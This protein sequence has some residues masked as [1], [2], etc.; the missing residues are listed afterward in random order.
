MSVP[1]HCVQDNVYVIESTTDQWGNTCDFV[2]SKVWVM[3]FNNEAHAVEDYKFF[4]CSFDE[5][6]DCFTPLMGKNRGIVG[7][8]PGYL[9]RRTDGLTLVS[10]LAKEFGANYGHG[11][12]AW[13]TGNDVEWSQLAASLLIGDPYDNM[14]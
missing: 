11:I 3:D 2:S 5:Q 14:V 7:G 13:R 10:A 12:K 8:W 4:S 9:S 6:L 1:A